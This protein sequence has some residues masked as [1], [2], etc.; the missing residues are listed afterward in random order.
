MSEISFDPSSELPPVGLLRRLAAIVYDLLLVVA[1][2]LTAT[3]LALWGCVLALGT[4]AVTAHNPLLG[5]PLF[6]IFLFLVCF[7]FYAWFWT[8]GG[9]TLGM[10]AWKIRVQCRTGA[11][12]TWLQAMRRFSMAIVSWSALGLGFWWM[13]VDRDRMTWHDRFSDT[14]LVRVEPRP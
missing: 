5:N 12:L 13:L 3:A 6:S 8:H 11:P 1:L 4:E 9:Q 10:Q 2:L 7:G 14:V